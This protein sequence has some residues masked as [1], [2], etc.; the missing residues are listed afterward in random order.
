MWTAVIFLNLWV[1]HCT[2]SSSPPSPINVSFSSLNLRNVLHWFPADGTP[3]HAH[4]NVEYAIYGDSI[5]GSKGR[6]VNWRAVKKCT[7]IVRTWCDLSNETWDLEQGYHARVR[8]VGRKSSSKWAVTRRRF[9]P[10]LDTSFGPPL[11]SVETENNSVTISLKGPMRYQPN[12]HT[13]VVSMAALYPQMTYNLSI[14]NNQRNQVHHFS[15]VTGPFKYQLMDYNT[16]YC[17]SAE[18]KFLSMPNQCQSSAWHCITTPKDPVIEQMQWVVVGIVVPSLCVCVIVVA[19][20][21]L[22]HYLTGK[23]QKSP[24]ILNPPSFHPPPLTFPP[25][26]LNFI[27]I[28]IIKD[29]SPLDACSVASKPACSKPQLRTT[30]AAPPCSYF[31]QGSEAPPLPGEHSDDSSIDY[32][33]ISTAPRIN[34]GRRDE[35]DGGSHLGGEDRMKEDDHPVAGYAPQAKSVHTCRQIQGAEVSTPVQAHA[36]SQVNPVLPEVSRMEEFPGLFINKNQQNDLFAIPLDLN[37]EVGREEKT[38]EE[39]RVRADRKKRLMKTKTCLFFLVT[40]PKTSNVPHCDQSALLS[41]DYGVLSRAEAQYAEEDDGYEEEEEQG[42]ICVNWDPKTGELRLPE[43]NGEEGLD[44][45]MLPYAARQD[46]MVGKDEEAFVMKGELTLE[47]VFVRQASEEDEPQKELE[48]VRET[49][50]EVDDILSKWNLTISM[51][52]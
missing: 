50:W 46:G 10:K 23:G 40:P 22:Y 5:K 26:N 2:V 49:E 12:N 25:E 11:V 44:R 36:W 35:G 9:D 15:V 7:E 17:F 6:R 24:Y 42:A 31:P 13:P 28:S 38:D 41:G 4:F 43:F 45:L 39:M 21:F 20:Y 29:D 51:D 19:A 1:L 14:R 27:L 48:Q 32:G 3:D 37:T 52:Q 33:F 34:M 8:A 16:E 47:N 30:S 18:S